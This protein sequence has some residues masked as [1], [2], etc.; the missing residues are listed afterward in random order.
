ML[1]LECWDTVKYSYVLAHDVLQ[2]LSGIL[3]NSFIKWWYLI[4]CV[5]SAAWENL[6]ALTKYC[7]ADIYNLIKPMWWSTSV[8]F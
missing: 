4:L 2:V 1:S 6:S 7:S 8:S 3:T 5:Q